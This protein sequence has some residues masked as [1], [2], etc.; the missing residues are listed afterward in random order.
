MMRHAKI[1]RDMS[2]HQ[3][4]I[5]SIRT[6]TD[7]RR[8]DVGIVTTILSHPYSGKTKEL[9]HDRREKNMATRPDG[10]RAYTDSGR[11][12]RSPGVTGQRRDADAQT[13]ETVRNT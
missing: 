6:R 10:R 13:S 9:R 8:R 5:A 11:G 4:P 12:V 7:D 2:L 3:F 1:C